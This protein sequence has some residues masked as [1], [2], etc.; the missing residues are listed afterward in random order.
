V[1]AAVTPSF[2]QTLYYPH[3]CELIDWSTMSEYNIRVCPSS[4]CTLCQK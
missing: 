4:R 1:A 3:N 2:A